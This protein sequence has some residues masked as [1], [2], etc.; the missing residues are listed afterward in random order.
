MSKAKLSPQ[1]FQTQYTRFMGMYG[2]GMPPILMYYQ[3][4]NEVN[5]Y[6]TFNG[7]CFYTVLGLEDASKYLS[8]FPNVIKLQSA[9]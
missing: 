2:D 8:I 6:M 1:D 4:N 7:V 5:V 3:I 9:Y